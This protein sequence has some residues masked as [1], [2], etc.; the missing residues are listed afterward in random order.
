VQAENLEEITKS[1]PTGLKEKVVD[2]LGDQ[3]EAMNDILVRLREGLDA[4][5]N[6]LFDPVLMQ[7]AAGFLKPTKT[8]SFGESLGYAA[9]MAGAA[10]ERELLQQR[11]NQKMEME[12]AQKEIELRQQLGGDAFVSQLLGGPKTVAP[13]AGAPAVGSAGAPPTGGVPTGVAGAQNPQQALLSSAAQGRIKIT[14]EILL[15]ANRINPKILPTLQ[16]I[17]KSQGEEEKNRIER[18]KLELMTSKVTPRGTRTERDLTYAQRKEYQ[19]ALDQYFIDGDEQKLLAFYDSKGW[20]D[21]EQ[22]RG[23]K[24]PKAGET[25]EPIPR[26][27]S[28]SEIDADKE[29]MTKTAAL[30]AEEAEKAAGRLLSAGRIAFAN[31]NTADDM[32]GY[33]TNNPRVFEIM[34]KP[35]IAGSVAR[36]AKEGLTTGNFS[37]S[38]PADKI[39]DYKLTKEDLTALQMFAQK[40]SELQ[41]RG[42]QLNRT[43]GEGS[44]SDF[45]TKL[46]GGIYALPSDNQRAIILKSQALKAQGAFDRAAAEIW[47]T[48]SKQPGYNYNDFTLDKDFL[49]LQKDYEATLKE[50]RQNNLDLLA[51]KR[52]E[53]E[54]TAPSAPAPAPSAPPKPATAPAPAPSAPAP[55]PAPSSQAPKN[56]TYS[57][58]LKRLQK[59][60]GG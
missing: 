2:D 46:L 19:A 37:V 51:P 13:P 23:R 8:G 31:S 20:L 6:R 52:K 34:N 55:A 57:E 28:Q 33:A 24:I 10:S 43:P 3:R 22:V 30:R 39:L 54:P 7:T 58:R 29:T 25:A 45:E 5:K 16:E 14:D 42:R 9:D 38:I 32:I 35:G 40:S 26:S 60:R 53:K 21:P 15:L 49:A 47:I 44:M 41:T 12:L 27:K 4:R 17:R 50:M 36:A 59:E 56:E 1:Q 11:E 48:K 18:E